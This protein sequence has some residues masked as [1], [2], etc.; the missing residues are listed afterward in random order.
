MHF[1]MLVDRLVAS[2]Q[3]Y[4]ELV[5]F[6]LLIIVQQ[7]LLLGKTQARVSLRVMVVDTSLGSCV[8]L[9]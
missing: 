2:V 6:E 9:S 1:L 3:L 4:V 7:S 5:R 8:P